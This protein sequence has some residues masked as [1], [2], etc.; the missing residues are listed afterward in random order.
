[1]P[2]STYD[3]VDARVTIYMKHILIIIST[4]LLSIPAWAEVIII[5]QDDFYSVNGVGKREILQDMERRAPYKKG[6]DTYPAYTQTDIKYN[7][8]WENRAG[9]CN[10]TDVKVYLTLT[11]VYPKLVR[12]QS[13]S[14]K[15]WWKDTMKKYVTHE[16]IHGDISKRWA[17]ELD[18]ELRALKDLNCG[19]AK[20][21]IATRAQYII[22]QM[23]KKQEEYDRVTKHGR[24]Q[25]K[26]QGPQ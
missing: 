8:S 9:R 13:G 18:R 7:Y 23:R 22:R 25:H 12:L 11:Y 21:T 14:V 20:Q 4:M 17:H 3:V 2:K 26:Y 1:M 10:V 19:T 15:W 6:N 24:L 5:E 16:Q